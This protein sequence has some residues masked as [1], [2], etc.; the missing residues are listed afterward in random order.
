LAVTET[1]AAADLTPS[2]NSHLSEGSFPVY[3]API[4]VRIKHSFIDLSRLERVITGFTCSYLYRLA[5]LMQHVF[6]KIFSA[7]KKNFAP[8]PARRPLRG[9]GAASP[10][11]FYAFARRSEQRD[12]CAVP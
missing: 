7:R 5:E 1:P 8:P 12:R 3:R 10:N 6:T 4:R 2:K 9:V 11:P